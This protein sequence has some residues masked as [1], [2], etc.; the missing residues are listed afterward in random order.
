MATVAINNSTNAALLA[1]RVLA[2][3]NPRLQTAVLQYQEQAKQEVYGKIEKL[4]QVG[5]MTY[6]E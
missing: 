5:W 1:I 6:K 2:A 3:A 4:E